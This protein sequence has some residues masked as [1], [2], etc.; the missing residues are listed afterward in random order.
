MSR[1]SIFPD[2][3]AAH[4][5][6]EQVTELESHDP[7]VIQAELSSRGICFEQ[8]PAEQ[9]LPEGAD[10]SAIIQA[11]ADAIARVQGDGGYATVDAIRMTPDHP[12]RELLRRKF[13]EEHIHAEDEVRFFVEGCGLFVLHI[14]SEVLS[15]L[16][17]RGDLMRVPAGTR[18]W[19]DMGSQP[20]FC[21][22]RWFNNPEGWVAQYTGSSI[23][24][25]FPRLD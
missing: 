16:C 10:Q 1:L 24:Q 2:E 11:Y 25:R 15:V 5:P 22:V 13:L 7:A 6:D 3:T 17:E 4:A 20:R 23:A 19:F 21:A 8:W 12:D 14:G 9:G 18:H